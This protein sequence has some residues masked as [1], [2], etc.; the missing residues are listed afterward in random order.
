MVPDLFS[1]IP[2]ESIAEKVPALRIPV[3]VNEK[4][5]LAANEVSVK[6][7]IRIVLDDAVAVHE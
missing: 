2:I 3:T 7:L 6:V 4:S 5:V 1:S